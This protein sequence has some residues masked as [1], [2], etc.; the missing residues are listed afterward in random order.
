MRAL[1][2]PPCP[3]MFHRSRDRA[4][5]PERDQAAACEGA[6]GERALTIGPPSGP[7]F[8]G[9]RAAEWLPVSVG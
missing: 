8:S 4:P 1:T 6:G 2:N 9:Q 7:R 5:D 3:E